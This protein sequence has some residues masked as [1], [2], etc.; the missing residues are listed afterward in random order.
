MTSRFMYLTENRMQDKYESDLENEAKQYMHIIVKSDVH[1]CR[2]AMHGVGGLPPF[3][4][5]LSLG[6]RYASFD[7]IVMCTYQ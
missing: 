1:H 2:W 4:A 6:M 3:Q 5:I 7:L